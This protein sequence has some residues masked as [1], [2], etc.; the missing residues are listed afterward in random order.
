VKPYIT[1]VFSLLALALANIA[2][3]TAQPGAGELT[4]ANGH[5]EVSYKSQLSPIAINQIHSWVLHVETAD[6]QAVTG[7]ELVIAGGMPE[8]N[9]GLATA[10]GFTEQGGGDYLLEG[11]RFHMMGYWELELSISA[12]GVKDK[13]IIALEL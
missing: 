8:H 9:H 7:A 12:G 4:S 11:L 6:G 3:V 13:V 1:A 2:V 5:F 10:P